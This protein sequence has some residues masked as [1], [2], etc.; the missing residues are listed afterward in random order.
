MATSAMKNG[1]DAC[2]DLETLAAYLEGRLTEQ[3]R[4]HIAEHL[5]SCETCYFVFTEAAQTR[6]ASMPQPEPVLAPVRW[7]RILPA[8][9]AG[10]AVAAALILAVRLGIFPSQST[11]STEMRA[12]V[13]AVGTDRAIAGRM[14]GGFQYG[15]LR[16]A[17]RGETISAASPDVRIA[18]AEVEKA[19]AN[20]STPEALRERGV[21]ELVVGDLDRSIAALEQA[22]DRRPS[23][24]R[25]QSDLAAAYLQ[26][27]SRTSNA[28]D[29]SRALA[30]A[31]RAI[32]TNRTHLEALFNRAVA[33][34]RLGMIA[35]ARSAWQA[36][37]TIDDRSGWADEARVHLRDL[38]ERR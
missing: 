36:Y 25:I 6:I 4:L 34:D 31:N 1:V 28:D 38:S 14:T 23:D 17:T 37:L 8:S 19:T 15:P 13:R 5:A 26:R 35:D 9:A 29:A 3:Q 22:A 20:A 10:L 11:D 16:S 18:A 30:A 24:P 33:L 12:L 2:P 7:S 32:T 27:A 21:A